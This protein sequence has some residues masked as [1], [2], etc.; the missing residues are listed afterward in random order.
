MVS[1]I[2]SEAHQ[3]TVVPVPSPSSSGRTC[4]SG[5]VGDAELEGLPPQVAAVL[6]LDDQHGVDRALT[7]ETPT[8]CRP[9]DT[10]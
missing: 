9:P 3:V 4:S 6:D 7:T 8:P 5:A 10:L 1:K 2:S